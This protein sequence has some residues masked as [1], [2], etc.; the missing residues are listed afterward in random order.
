MPPSLSERL[1]VGEGCSVVL[2]RR[3]TRGAIPKRCPD[4]Q[5]EFRR[6]C[7]DRWRS[8]N[9]ERAR[10]LDRESQRRR[11]SEDPTR[12]R[13][14]KRNST[15]EQKRQWKRTAALRRFGLTRTAYDELLA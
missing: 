7:T 9:P 6:A 13:S 1:C 12:Y 8:E 15:P 3:G 11:R 4:C 14:Y 10:E 2:V 5:L